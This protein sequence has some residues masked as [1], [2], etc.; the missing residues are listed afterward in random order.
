MNTS[1]FLRLIP[2]DNGFPVQML[3]SAADLSGV[4]LDPVFV[5]ARRAHVV[6]VELQVATVH[7]GQHQTKSVFGLVRIR[8]T[9]LWKFRNA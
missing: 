7:D 8:Q 4:K 9:H 6:D 5:E 1:L 2:V 3:E